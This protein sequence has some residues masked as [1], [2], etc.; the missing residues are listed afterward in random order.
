MVLDLETIGIISGAV[1]TISGVIW[2]IIERNGKKTA[3]DILNRNSKIQNADLINNIY[4]GLL[5]DVNL[6]ETYKS[7]YFRYCLQFCEKNINEFINFVIQKNNEIN[8]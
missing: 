8:N 3:Q 7:K 1:G 4:N 6:G 2:G 5:E